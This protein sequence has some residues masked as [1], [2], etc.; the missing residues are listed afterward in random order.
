M[1][2]RQLIT[3]LSALLAVIL[4][5]S[6]F[7]SC[8]NQ[9]NSGTESETESSTTAEGA[10]ELSTQLSDKEPQSTGSDAKESATKDSASEERT[11]KHTEAKTEVPAEQNALRFTD[12]GNGTCAVSGIGNCTDLFV[13]IP[14]RSPEGSVVTAIEE[15]AFFA[16]RDVKAFEIPSTVSSIGNMAFGDCPSL[17]YISVDKSNKSFTDIAGV[18]YTKDESVLLHYPSASGSAE[19]FLSSSVTRIADMAFYGCDT[20]RS[21]RYEG[22]L[23]DWGKITIGEMNYGL[24]TASVSCSGK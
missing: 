15:K 8:G 10:L 11:E 20:L 6:A 18:L 13:V 14:E 12:Y 2:R 19:L 24:F 9:A 5:T 23:S 3:T 16:N 17:V 1:K 7:A 22:T 21:I 4:L